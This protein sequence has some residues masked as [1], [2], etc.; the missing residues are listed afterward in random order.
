MTGTE[1][2]REELR[3]LLAQVRGGE[4]LVQFTTKAPSTLAPLAAH[5][6]ATGRPCVVMHD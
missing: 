3:P 6:R 5:C 1:V 4:V 2:P